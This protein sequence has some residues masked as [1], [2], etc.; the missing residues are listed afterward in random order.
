MTRSEVWAM[1]A[2]AALGAVGT[3]NLVSS[4]RAALSAAADADALM[5]QYEKRWAFTL[6]VDNGTDPAK[7]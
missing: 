2:A 5:A 4:K 3:T 1:F 7:P 6:P